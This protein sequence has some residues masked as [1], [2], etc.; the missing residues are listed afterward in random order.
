MQYFVPRLSSS[1]F[2]N[3]SEKGPNTRTHQGNLNLRYTQGYSETQRR[4]ILRTIRW[5]RQ[6]IIITGTF[7]IEPFRR[8]RGRISLLAHHRASIGSSPSSSMGGHP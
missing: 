7:I 6:F 4:L 3:R 2:S 8:I 5:T 1:L